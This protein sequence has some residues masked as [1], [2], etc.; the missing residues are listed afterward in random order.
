MTQGLLAMGRPGI[1]HEVDHRRA[2]SYGSGVSEPLCPG[3]AQADGG[4]DVSRADLG[5]L[6]PCRGDSFDC[7]V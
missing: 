5:E 1:D 4:A 3:T 2:T 7:S 6:L